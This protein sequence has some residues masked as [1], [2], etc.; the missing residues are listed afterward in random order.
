MC[1]LAGRGVLQLPSL[2][3]AI[4]DRRRARDQR[5]AL[6]NTVTPAIGRPTAMPRDDAVSTFDGAIE[7]DV[8]ARLFAVM[9]AIAGGPTDAVIG[10]EPEDDA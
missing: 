4:R 5:T 6:I 3:D 7:V 2:D 8:R 10:P 1:D 9:G